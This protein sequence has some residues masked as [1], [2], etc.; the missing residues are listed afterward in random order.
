MTTGGLF[1]AIAGATAAVTTGYPLPAATAGARAPRSAPVPALLLL[2]PL[3]LGAALAALSAGRLSGGVAFVAVGIT[4][5][6]P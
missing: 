5:S 2:A 4:K 6:Q 3:G 1:L